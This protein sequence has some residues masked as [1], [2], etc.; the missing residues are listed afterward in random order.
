MG[1]LRKPGNVGNQHLTDLRHRT[2]RNLAQ[3]LRAQTGTSRQQNTF[4][5]MRGQAA[6]Q[7]RSRR[8][9]PRRAETACQHPALAAA[10]A[11][12][13]LR[14]ASSSRGNTD[15]ITQRHR[16]SCHRQRPRRD[17]PTAPSAVRACCKNLVRRPCHLQTQQN[18]HRRSRGRNEHRSASL[19]D[20]SSQSYWSGGDSHALLGAPLGA[21]P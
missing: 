13:P 18:P 3:T 7:Q 2:Q 17:A 15:D 8:A 4:E 6:L 10:P 11:Q 5:I 20:H 21:R 1:R 14:A 19:P 12:F 9:S 16:C